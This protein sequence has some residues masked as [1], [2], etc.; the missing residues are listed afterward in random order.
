MINVR[1]VRIDTYFQFGYCLIVQGCKQLNRLFGSPSW[2]SNFS[3]LVDS[4][5]GGS[6]S[7]IFEASPWE[8]VSYNPDDQ[9]EVEEIDRESGSSK[10]G[11]ESRLGKFFF[12][13]QPFEIA[14]RKLN[15]C[16]YRPI[17]FLA[18]G[19]LLVTITVAPKAIIGGSLFLICV[20]TPATFV[21]KALDRKKKNGFVCQPWY[22]R[23]LKGEREH[24]KRTSGGWK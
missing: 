13:V 10:I 22:D 7:N 6:K 1:R 12:F 21:R 3:T 11:I 17:S 15:T 14:E 16:G 24:I 9:D 4:V 8:G 18:Y 20:A 19:T 23:K 5:K 2:R